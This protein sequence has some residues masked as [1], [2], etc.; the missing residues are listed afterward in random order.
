LRRRDRA[1]RR[2]EREEIDLRLDAL[3]PS[4]PSPRKPSR[5]KPKNRRR[6]R[7][8]PVKRL[9]L[10]GLLLFGVAYGIY[11]LAAVNLDG[12]GE[13][14]TVAVERGDTLPSV[15]DKL[16][17]A[18]VIRSAALFQ[19][20]ARLRDEETEIKAG[21]YEFTPGA[22][23]EEIRATLASGE[24]VPALT[25]TVPE[26]LTLEQ[27]AL[28]VEEQSGIPAEEFEAAAA[29]TDYEYEFLVD[30][31]VESTEGFLFPKKYE[32]EEGVGAEQVVDRLLRQY[33]TETEDLDFATAQDRLGLTEYE[34]LTTASLVEEE[35]ANPEERPI[36]AGVI[37]NRIRAG[38]P[39]QVDAT[40]LYVLGEPKAS[41]SL[42]DLEVDSPYNT[43]AN[44]GLPP[45]PI[46]S[47]SR[48]SIEAALRP[49]ETGYLYYVLE[50]GGQEHFFTDDYDEFLE[51]KDE[52]EEER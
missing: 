12:G 42:E 39:L 14:V 20:E 35:S 22:R 36:I 30:T 1:R 26:G 23:G 31:A 34:L 8:S 13:P 16:E 33:R 51:A 37:Y 29:R 28:A 47:P 50:A 2:R 7:R 52:A 32:F 27:T 21:E 5:R 9:A 3:R 10:V 18:G 46:A 17:A 44:K 6:R 25:I 15:A 40:I 41:L 4:D 45:G 19:V 38:M 43:Y 48:E 11:L 24:S 49:A